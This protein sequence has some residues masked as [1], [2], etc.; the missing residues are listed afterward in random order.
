MYAK[1]TEHMFERI[2]SRINIFDTV[3]FG[4]SPEIKAVYLLFTKIK[5]NYNN[6]KNTDLINTYFQL[7][8]DYLEF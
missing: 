1:Y 8:E 3:M 2:A 6:K 7:I 5:I 4:T